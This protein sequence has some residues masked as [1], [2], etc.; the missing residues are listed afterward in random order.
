MLDNIKRLFSKFAPETSQEAPQAT[1]QDVRVAACALFL[2]MARI[3]EK[4]TDEEMDTFLAEC[5]NLLKE[6]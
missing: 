4:F 3:D 2:E 1:E 6:I 5:R